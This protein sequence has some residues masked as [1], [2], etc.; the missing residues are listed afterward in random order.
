MAYVYCGAC[1]V[2]YN[3]TSSLTSCV[4]GF[5]RASDGSARAANEVLELCIVA[6][7]CIKGVLACCLHNLMQRA[8]MVRLG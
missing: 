6:K 8:G 2:T 4:Q 1:T 5:T 3:L 7:A